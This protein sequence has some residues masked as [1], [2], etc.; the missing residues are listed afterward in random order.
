MAEK[1]QTIKEKYDS[2]LKEIRTQK[3][4][5]VLEK[6]YE[7][8]KQNKS[9]LF[10]N[11]VVPF[12]Y[13]NDLLW[14]LQYHVIKIDTQLDIYK[15]YLDEFFSLKCKPEDIIKTEIFRHIFNIETNFYRNATNIENILVFLN[16]FFNVYYP[17]NISIE[18]E[19]GD[20]MDV[21]VS[22]EVFKI[23]LFGWV[24]L[25]IKRIEKEK[26]LYIFED[27]KD[28]NKEI[29]ISIDNF[30]VQEKNTFVKE[31]EMTWRNNLKVGDKVDYL[32]SN[33]NW[34]EGYVKEINDNG[35]IA[36]KAMGEID[37]NIIFLK[38]YSPFIQ[39][40]LKYSFKYGPDEVNCIN[41]L[42]INPDFQ[43]FNYFIP[44]TETNHFIPCEDLKIFS[45]EY[46]E[47][48]NFFVNKLLSTKVLENETLSIEYIYTFLN[49]LV[50][51]DRLIN[52]R[53]IGKY[54][55]EKC[56][57][58][59]KKILLDVSLNKKK[60]ISKVLIDGIVTYVD[61]LL[62]F[63]F[64][65]FQLMKLYPSFLIIF[66]YNC[67]KNSENLEK[68][69]IG[70]NTISKILPIINKYLP[71]VGS[72]VVSEI[73]SV[74]SDKLLNNSGN[75]DDLFGLLF[76]TPNIHEQLL[77]KGVEVII[78]LT[79]LKL[80]DD[81]DIDR[82]YN[83]ALS[84]PSDSDIYSSIYNLLNKI[85]PELSLSQGK[86]IFDKIITFPY[87]KI[88]QND[89]E[90][91]KNI[92]QNINSK[93]DFRSMTKAFLD[94]YYNFMIN[95]T[96][97]DEKYNK[98]FGI[99][100]SYAKD[101]DNL[102]YLYNYYFEKVINELN[103][104][105]NLE[106]YRYYF[107]LIHSIFN[108]LSFSNEKKQKIDLT[109]IKSKFKEIFYKNFKDFGII[110][111]KALDLNNKEEKEK[112]EDYIKDIMDIVNGF[113]DLVEDKEFYTLD[114]MLKLA[115]Y[116]VFGDKVR[117]KRK[118]FLYGL[119]F[120]KNTNTFD[121]NEF[122]ELLFNKLDNFFNSITPEKPE[123]YDLLD[124]YFV[125]AVFSLYKE[126]NKNKELVQDATDEKIIYN[127]YKINMT[128]KLNPLENKYFDI[129]WK[130]FMKFN[131]PK[132]MYEY[133]E[134]FSL[135][136]FTPSERHEI[137]E[138]L[139]KKIFSDIDINII[140][141]LRMIEYILKFSEK[142][143]SGGVVSHIASTKKKNI[144]IIINFTNHFSKTLTFL[145]N[146]TIPTLNITST[147]FDIKKW[148]QKK[149]GIDP[150]FL[151]FN[152]TNKNESLSD[153][154]KTMFQIFPKL[155]EFPK[156][157]CSLTF[158]RNSMINNI[159]GYPLM[160][161][162]KTGLTD[163]FLE[164]LREI[165]NKY[166]DDGKMDINNYKIYF[167]NA[168]NYSSLETT[169]EI[170][171]ISTFHTFDMGKKGYWTIDDF[172]NFHANSVQEKKN[173]IFLNLQNLGYTKSL[174][175]YFG[176][177]KKDSL[178]YYEENNV[179]EYM[180]R[181][182]IGNNRQYM[183]KLFSYAKYEN[184]TIHELAQNLLKELCTL[185]EI[186]KSLFEN[187]NKID[188]ILS[189][190]N[191]ELRAYAYD[192]LLS[193]FENNDDKKDEATQN[194][195]NNFINNN[196]YKLI[197][198][199][200]KYIKK[201][202]KKENVINTNE[203]EANKD[204]K[205]EEKEEEKENIIKN[206]F[207]TSLF[208]NY[209]LSNLK[210]LYYAFKNIINNKELID[211]ID[212]F[213]D[214]E[215]EN[216]KNKKKA[217]KI[218]LDEE[219]KN[220]IKKLDFYKL[221]NIIGNNFTILEKNPNALYKQGIRLSLK[222]LI[223][224]IL[225]S[226]D[227]SEE[228]KT[229]I[230]KIFLFYQIKL[231]QASSFFI[232]RNIFVMN[233]LI[234]PFMNE[235]SDKKFINLQNEELMKEIKNYN[236]LNA[237]SGKLMF[238]FRLFY[239]LYDLSIKDTKNDEIFK[240]FEELL[241]IILDK[242][243]EL[244][245]YILIG[246]LGIIKRILTILK[247]SKYPKLYEYS[248]ESLISKLINDFLITFDKDENNKIIEVNKLKKYSKYSDFEYVS[249]IYQIINIIISLNPEKYLK[250]FFENEEIKNVR[251]K[252]L[253][254]LEDEKIGYSPKGESISVTGFV[255]LKNLSCLC[256]INSVIQQFFMIQLF[257]NAILSL[258]LEAGLKED[259]DNDI[260]LF[261][262]QKMFYYLKNS[263][264]EHYNPKSF[265]YSFKDYDGNP[266][267]INVQC[268]AQEFLSRLIE[269]IDESL[270]NNSQKYLC[271]NIFGG[272]TLQQVKCTNP[273]CGN[274]SERKEN[275]NYLSLDIKD[276]NTV[277]ECLQKFIVEEKI[278]DYHCEKCDKKITNI[279][280]VLIDKIPNILII[281]L[282]RIAF[283]YETFNMEKINKTITFEKTLNIKD[284]TINKNNNDIP[285]DYF[286]YELQG[287]L[288]H[289]GTAQF[290]HYYSMIYSKEN[291]IAGKWYKF[292]DTSVT[293]SD[294]DKVETEGFGNNLK[295]DYGASAYMLIYQKKIKKPVIIN[296]KEINEN[297]KK[298]LDENKEKNLEKVD[299]PDG[300]IYYV[301]ENDKDVVEKNIIYNKKENENV[302]NDK[303]IIIKNGEI[304]AD[305]VTYEEALDS[306]KK[307]NSEPNDKKP[308]I[309]TIF[310]EN[311]KLCND[312]KFFTKGFT[313]FMK[314]ISEVIKKEILDDKANTKIN[315]YISILKTINDYILN[316]LAK[317]NYLDDLDK[318]VD[319]I[320][321][322][323]NH[324]VPK[325]LISYLIKDIIDPIKEKLYLNYFVCR[326]R[327]MGNDI[328]NYV[329][330]IICCALNNNI[331]VEL[332]MKIIQFY[333][334]KIPIE[335]TKKWVDME[336]FNNLIL[337]LIENS[338]IVKKSFIQNN[339]ISKLIDFILGKSSPFYQGDD[340]IENKFNKGKFGPIVKSIAL[341]FK[342]YNENHE[343]EEIKLSPSDSKL[344]NHK[345][346]YE[347][348]VLDDYDNNACNLLIDNK[349]KLSLILNKDDN[350]EDFDKEILDILI[351]LKIPSI[352]K[353]EEIISALELIINLI[354]KYS[355]I[356]C[357]KDNNNN[358]KFMEKLNILLGLPI[359]TVTS[360]EA[361]IKYISGKY[362]DQYT[363][364]T[365]I[366]KQRDLNRDAIPLL[367][368]LF[369]LININNMVF[370]YMDNLP[371]PNS[372]K[373]SYLDFC[374]KLFSLT[375][376]V[377]KDE[378]KVNEEMGMNNPLKELS[379][380]VNDIC[381]KNNKDL[382]A[383]KEN[384]K[385]NITESIYIS[386]FSFDT[387]K[388]IKN[389]E[390][391]AVYEAKF[392]YTTMKNVKK[393]DLPCFNKKTY[394]HNLI[395]RKGDNN[396]LIEDGLEQYTML[397]ILICCSIDMD[398]IIDFKP[399]IYSKMEI[400][401]K[402]EFHYFFY[403]M[404]YNEDKKI[405]YS[406]MNINIKDNQPLALPAPSSDP[407]GNSDSDGCTINCPVCGN[408]NI[409]NEAN[410]EFKCTYCESSLF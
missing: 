71:I 365:N 401:G 58:N 275:I 379:N 166:S 266:T 347:K 94:Y 129:I 182:F 280:K 249:N 373:Y 261:Q 259:E 183:S 111:D 368:S 96:N 219:K 113:I 354:K 114:S 233:K 138:K 49:L 168:M 255:G 254:K 264:K 48:C 92:L 204:K 100:M 296:S 75:N 62:S 279:K 196:L 215:D 194:L 198:E 176:P 319:N 260:L 87:D 247:Q 140:G 103:N 222:I 30:K 70:L 93:E 380:L 28:N 171:A 127:N 136:N 82:L 324:S 27:Y 399:Y 158:K 98:D 160:N 283:S 184:K 146:E 29:M 141:C 250:L 300:K 137:W 313:Q 54:F 242:N 348:V 309:N 110:V 236:K 237:Y 410:T 403:C 372:T 205:E 333:L 377:T 26:N 217:I 226:K 13:T 241:N 303:N 179:K 346:F 97:K 35:E 31:D 361:E 21:F 9:S 330:K 353:K 14:F 40:L 269:K 63:N 375:E 177:L 18:H 56:F 112:N 131:N 83:L 162:D 286:D 91:M 244:G 132:K 11:N 258:P 209:Y 80:L 66:G 57:E 167:N 150:I 212:K 335:V 216:E 366:S 395:S 123:R 234:L 6:I 106:D 134:G 173:A 203:N 38:K 256:Y 159:R 235:E 206:E 282:Q 397:C 155:L 239:D 89:I 343:K 223:Y 115:D 297:I 8:L 210:I 37:Q 86:V 389:T 32:T 5:S 36:I 337:T 310:L 327:I 151:D 289:S 125:N 148:L 3:S 311:I 185:E 402:K 84:A 120:L 101:E 202:E 326:D 34:V 207:Q 180:P 139:V 186:K 352:K 145:K 287:V 364:L 68:R 169:M 191:L 39:P 175:Y 350:N 50:F 229:K 126:I 308:F 147:L 398:I 318:I 124:E 408:V 165:F 33:K 227:L 149:F 245:E 302:N 90:L 374:L 77:L 390:K 193:E 99:I 195:T 285:S 288:I 231:I 323:Y 189:N 272:S 73:T 291:D 274:I 251:E 17:K 238:F 278:E 367:S 263:K 293:E 281:H 19:V 102:N 23:N 46:Y 152:I 117:K 369:N 331:E 370:T 295:H 267:N 276:S 294:F 277:L 358:E 407:Y 253:T 332:S 7:D 1:S 228:E 388:D 15:L 265:V 154:S 51:L 341:L 85:T 174:D 43:K 342:Y 221:I 351:Q 376:V 116:F 22:D 378:F 74:I 109:F 381:T 187:S 334:D 386:E 384:S 363:I 218:I 144:F 307:I 170:K 262:L 328:S 157:A 105:N 383:I 52:Q 357:N 406:T 392:Y 76:N 355:E 230:Y 360:G 400:K 164:V 315:E 197:I 200:D 404:D 20:I 362:Q 45:L 135:K 268:D 156:E 344:I 405:D 356:Y 345:P 53:F 321:D 130:M 47:M 133:L 128:E 391:V 224:V 371:A 119:V 161:E 298:I 246:Y 257:K 385:I 60:N 199:L 393:T 88:R 301:Y 122:F 16:R 225:L 78:N 41:L 42:E 2:L 118:D 178:L 299:L 190:N 409:I 349:M 181:Y 214:L 312:K 4:I 292:N 213:E 304:E 61:K 59:I 44:V 271:N 338:D 316:I 329:G 220:L 142:Y 64:Y 387:I 79:K 232:K 284:Y 211:Y 306:F 339:M 24:Q 67:F 163:K 104:Q 252:H 322:I 243:I 382:N 340:R 208:F 320:T 240:F 394:F 55:Y 95:Y 188:E 107:T 201:D 317:S 10:D 69:L 314:Q 325:E 108:S 192:I 396:T 359:P 290:G 305:L 172:I 143:G 12:Q 72:D 81:K 248:F 270:K 65:E 336:S 153:Y 273:D 121:K 25:P